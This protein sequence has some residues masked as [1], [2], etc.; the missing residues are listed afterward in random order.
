VLQLSCDALDMHLPFYHSSRM[1][2]SAS[3]TGCLSW[4][5]E[6]ALVSGSRTARGLRI[7]GWARILFAQSFFSWSTMAGTGYMYQKGKQGEKKSTMAST[8]YMCQ[9]GKQGEKKSTMAGT[10][11]I[12]KEV[13]KERRRR[14]GS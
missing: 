14:D 2:S 10:G 7:L 4:V 5:R 12:T 1:L 9:K 6:G 3:D 8:G 13:S 11:Y